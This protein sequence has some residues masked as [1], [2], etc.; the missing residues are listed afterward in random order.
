MKAE[1]F[2]ALDLNIAR[3]RVMLSLVALLSIYIDPS[4]GGIFHLDTYILAT[5]LCHLAYSLATYFALSRGIAPRTLHQVSTALDIFF[6]TAVTLFT[7]GP[8]SP[9]YVF[10]VFAIVAVGFRT[11]FRATLA[12]TGVCV[13]LYLVVIAIPQGLTNLYVMR[14]VYLAIAGYLIG[15]FGQQRAKFEARLRELEAVGERQTIARSLHDG[16]VQALAGVTLRL[17][18]CR[19]LLLRQRPEEALQELT[20][21]RAGVA[22]EYDE[23]RAYIRTLANLD[24]KMT[25]DAAMSHFDTRFR[26]DAVFGGRG[27]IVEQVFAVIL[28]GMRNTWRHGRARSAVIKVCE[29]GAVVRITIDDDGVGFPQSNAP[30]WAIASRVAE[31]GGSVRING[32]ADAGAHLEIEMP[33]S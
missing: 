25:V 2:G 17:G 20:D 26:I 7:E 6:A 23:I 14:A 9:S 32:A 10:F 24:Q 16:Y 33:A 22:R 29:A 3:A 8:T 12:I 19:E 31:C 4:A 15:F 30:P 27:P 1:D 13:M 5:L 11:A 21:L 18:T 28:E